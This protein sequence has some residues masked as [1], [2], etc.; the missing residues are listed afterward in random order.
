MGD[1]AI[2]LMVSAYTFQD[3]EIVWLTLV[4]LGCCGMNNLTLQPDTGG[5]KQPQLI[6]A[7]ST[8]LLIACSGIL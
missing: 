6:R 3:E 7:T 8:I 1:L 5:K 4:V 2:S